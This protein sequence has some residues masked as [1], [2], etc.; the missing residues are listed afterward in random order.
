MRIT[1]IETR[2]AEYGVRRWSGWRLV[3]L[4]SR[5]N[6]KNDVEYRPDRAFDLHYCWEVVAVSAVPRS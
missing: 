5:P 1:A 3:L 6:R 4:A 2:T